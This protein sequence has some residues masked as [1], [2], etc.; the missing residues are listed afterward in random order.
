VVRRPAAVAIIV[1][2]VA[3]PA[4]SVVVV[5][6]VVVT[7]VVDA[8]SPSTSLDGVPRVTVRPKSALKR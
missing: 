6:R 1:A 4:S 3:S 2:V 5:A 8:L 7:M